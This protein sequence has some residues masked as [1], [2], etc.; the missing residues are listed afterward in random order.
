MSEDTPF[1][2]FYND[3]MEVIALLIIAL[4]ASDKNGV[5]LRA[6]V[7]GCGCLL[8]LLALVGFAGYGLWRLI[9][10]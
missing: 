5:P 2:F 1:S 10:G 7:A 8:A 9:F 3:D 4:I 6:K